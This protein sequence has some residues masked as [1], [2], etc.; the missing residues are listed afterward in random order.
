MLN[1][2]GTLPVLPW[3]VTAPP[4]HHQPGHPPGQ[5][6]IQP[7][8]QR[9]IG[10]RPQRHQGQFTRSF[11]GQTQQGQGGGLIGQFAG[12]FGETDIAKAILPVHEC[13]VF[14]RCPHQWRGTSGEHRYRRAEQIDQRA[15][16]AYGM[17]EPHVARGDA[18]ARDVG[19]RMRHQDRQRVVDAGVGINQQLRSSHG[20]GALV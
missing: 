19:M 18:Q 5:R 11:S 13:G 16:V 8:R 9:K 20:S 14:L 2:A 15:R 6:R 12:R 7:Q 1:S 10:Q 4:H 17:T 3:P